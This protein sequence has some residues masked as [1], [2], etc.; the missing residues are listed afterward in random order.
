MAKKKASKVATSSARMRASGKRPSLLW[1]DNSSRTLLRR[2]AVIDGRPLTQF[3]I[4]HG[5]A[6]AHKILA[7]T[8]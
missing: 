4:H 1:L 6:A 7:K 8:S 3:L 5:L 2:A